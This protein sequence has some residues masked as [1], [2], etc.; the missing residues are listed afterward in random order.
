MLTT[1]ELTELRPYLLRLAS[2]Y[3]YC[4]DCEELVQE[5]LIYLWEERTHFDR[6]RIPLRAWGARH[7]RAMRNTL[8]DLHRLNH[9]RQTRDSYGGRGM[10]TTGRGKEKL[11][12]APPVD[13]MLRD[14]LAQAAT[15]EKTSRVE[16]GRLYAAMKERVH[17]AKVG[18]DEYSHPFTWRSWVA[19][20]IPERTLRDIN[21]C[22]E[23][24]VSGTSC[25]VKQ[26]ENVLS[27]PKSVA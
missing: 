5:T 18:N 22:I 9:P 23:D 25:P 13:A 27:F 7:Q 17:T 19:T 11:R 14:L 3:G 10:M 12:S 16:L 8:V 4:W 15:V 1:D 24:Y 21:R 20:Y 6:T 26:S 2:R